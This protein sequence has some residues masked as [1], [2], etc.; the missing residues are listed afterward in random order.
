MLALMLF[1]LMLL[2]FLAEVGVIVWDTVWLT[3][4]AALSCYL[5]GDSGSGSGAN[6][7]GLR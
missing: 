4:F 5:V 1:V 6:I 2:R 3:Y 7:L